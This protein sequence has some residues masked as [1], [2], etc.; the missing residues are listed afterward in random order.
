METGLFSVSKTDSLTNQIESLVWERNRFFVALLAFFLKDNGD[1]VYL[2]P[3]FMDQ[4]YNG[5]LSRYKLNVETFPDGDIRI[6]LDKGSP[7]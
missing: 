3:E 4:F 7:R 1:S 5:E 2:S 6:T